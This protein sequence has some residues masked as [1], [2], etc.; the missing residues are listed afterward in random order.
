MSFRTLLS[1]W[2]FSRNKV[3]MNDLRD[4]MFQIRLSRPRLLATALETFS[5]AE[6]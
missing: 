2:L 4:V 3:V 6:R 1:G 5:R